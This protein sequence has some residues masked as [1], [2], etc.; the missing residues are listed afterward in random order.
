MAIREEVYGD[1]IPS[2]TLIGIGAAKEIPAKIKA[3]GDGSSHDCEK[4]VVVTEE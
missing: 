2:V 3:L 4:G 1:F